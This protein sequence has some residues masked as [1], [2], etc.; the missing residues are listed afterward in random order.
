MSTAQSLPLDTRFSVRCNTLDKDAAQTM[1]RR[2]GC[3]D[4][5]DA[6][7]KIV[8]WLSAADDGVVKIV[9]HQIE[10]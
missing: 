3:A 9:K 6:F 7:R 4:T 8:R 5:S 2:L 1:A 10:S